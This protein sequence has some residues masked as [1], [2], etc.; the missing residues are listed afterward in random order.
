MAQ[1]EEGAAA[2]ECEGQDAVREPPRRELAE[3]VEQAVEGD[4]LVVAV[5]APAQIGEQRLEVARGAVD[6]PAPQ[7]L[8]EV[9]RIHFRSRVRRAT[10]KATG[11]P[12][13]ELRP[14]E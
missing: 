11:R 10:P 1:G 8:E 13:D 6:A 7:T 4:A 3:M 9:A 12:L 2:H 5:V 14:S